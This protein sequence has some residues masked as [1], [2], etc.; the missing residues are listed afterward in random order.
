MHCQTCP[1]A[2]KAKPTLTAAPITKVHSVYRV[3]SGTNV[4]VDTGIPA[5]QRETTA[6]A[7]PCHRKCGT[8]LAG[9]NSTAHSTVPVAVMVPDPLA[10]PHPQ[11][12]QP[13]WP[14]VE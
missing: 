6:T 11:A 1:R 12:N 8:A 3:A 10:A 2:P 9:P 13:R 7:A 14:A 5:A 4:F